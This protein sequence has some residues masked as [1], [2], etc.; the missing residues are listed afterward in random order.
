MSVID[1]LIANN[2]ARGHPPSGHADACPSRR[3]A[4]VT[5]MDARIDPAAA[6]GLEPG[7]AHVLRNAGTAVTDDVIR[8]LAI[9]QRLLG[10]REVMVIKHTRCGM[11]DL[12]EDRLRAELAESA[13]TEPTWAI[14][15]FDDL[16]DAVRKAVARVRD[17]PF[18]A[19]RDRV[20]GFVY[21]VQTGRL[22]EVA[23]A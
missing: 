16:D 23:V 14:E 3:V 20:R 10:T 15:S 18:L 19:H 13:G 11:Q 6:L 21:D 12:D 17:S 2:R 22:R 4:I 1:E 9:S 7:E 5:C 8:S